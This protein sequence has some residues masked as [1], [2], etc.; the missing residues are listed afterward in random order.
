MAGRVLDSTTSSA[1]GEHMRKAIPILSGL[2]LASAA[3]AQ[4]ARET[5]TYKYD[6]LGRLVSSDAR[7]IGNGGRRTQYAYDKAS[8]RERVENVNIV[9]AGGM[10]ANFSLRHGE[11]IKSP[12]N[13]YVLHLQQDGNLV[14]YNRDTAA[15]W[16]T[17]T[18]DRGQ[19][20][21]DMQGDGNLVLYASNGQVVWNTGTWGN[22][23]AYAELTDYGKL[24]LRRADGSQLW[25][26]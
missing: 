26:N 8:N 1:R 13:Q 14:I 7:P 12:G 19:N 3:V 16:E 10:P 15:T 24:V 5:V 4:D 6:A 23:G 20:H 25:S 17:M 21:L 2:I 18:G 9:R 22:P 11:G